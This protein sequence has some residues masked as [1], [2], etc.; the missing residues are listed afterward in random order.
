MLYVV[1]SLSH[2]GWNSTY[3]RETVKPVRIPGYYS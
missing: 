3:T 1:Q 2:V